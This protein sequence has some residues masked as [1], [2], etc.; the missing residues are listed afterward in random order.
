MLL[1]DVLVVIWVALFAVQGAYR[2]LVA[3]ALSLVGLAL[4]AL[5]GSWIAPKLLSEGSAWVSIASLAGAIVGAALLGAASAGLAEGP[6]RFIAF[7]PGLRA[8]D[9]IGG[10]ALGGALG[11]ALAWLIGVV[12]V[13]QPSLG[14]RQDVR[15]ST[16]LP[17]LMRAVP[18]D[19][20]LQA[21]ARFDPFPEL[22]LPGERL[23]APDPSVRRSPGA[24]AAEASVVKI[25]GTA[26]GLGIQGS[27]WVVRRDLVA[28][29]AHVIAGEHDTTV[30]APNGQSLSARV[31]YVDSTNDVALLRVEAL[32]TAP[33]A[34]SSTGDYPVKVVLMGYP[35]DGGLTAVAGTAGSPRTVL[36]PNAYGRHPG[37]RSVV[38][39]RGQVQPGDSGGPV[40]DSD[41]GVVAMIFGGSNDGRNGFA[42]PVSVVRDAVPKA[43]GPV[44]SGPC[45][46]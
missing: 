14:F 10:F 6:R 44:A 18:P 8:A 12:A 33:L 24:R 46:G 21:L 36:A 34:V 2:G 20:V 29:N 40:V 28:T 22:A 5:A 30:L 17:R 7:R 35:R 41:G 31:V 3:Q 1:V 32:R 19:A 27:G 45:I 23:P 37:P 38:P 16:I 13:Q 39:L 25:H 9:T 42:V 43:T 15:Q 26:C 4:G 11:L